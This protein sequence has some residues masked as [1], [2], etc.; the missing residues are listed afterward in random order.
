[1]FAELSGTSRYEEALEV[2]DVVRR[3]R[4]VERTA[5]WR[6]MNP[7]RFAANRRRWKAKWRAK[8][9]E[10]ARAQ[11]QRYNDKHREHVRALWRRAK[12]KRS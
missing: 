12:A 1:M 5:L 8:Y 6:A 10:K 4:A 2:A 9:P 7:K 11:K 3:R